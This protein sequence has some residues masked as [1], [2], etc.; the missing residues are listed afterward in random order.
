KR[1]CFT[2]FL[3][4]STVPARIYTACQLFCH[5]ALGFF[6]SNALSLSHQRCHFSNGN[7]FLCYQLTVF[8]LRTTNTIGPLCT[9]LHG[10]AAEQVLIEVTRAS[11]IKIPTGSLINTV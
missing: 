1:V 9:L 6:G 8:Y 3:G 7:H 5:P 11:A 10:I 4:L 2:T